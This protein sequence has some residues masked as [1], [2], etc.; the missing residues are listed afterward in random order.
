MSTDILSPDRVEVAPVA[1]GGPATMLATRR[2]G[3]PGPVPDM[4]W[5]RLS[6]WRQ[7]VEASGATGAT[8]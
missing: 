3:P 1:R 2:S 8:S 5:P 4:R 6:R 7:K